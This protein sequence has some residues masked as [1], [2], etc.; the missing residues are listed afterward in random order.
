MRTREYKGFILRNRCGGKFDWFLTHNHR[1]RWGSLD[2]MRAD[3]EH[4]LTFGYFPAAKPGW[5]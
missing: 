2:E 1:T 3:V 4:I 5:A